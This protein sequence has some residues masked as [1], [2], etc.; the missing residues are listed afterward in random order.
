V[1][2]AEPAAAM[3]ALQNCLPPDTKIFIDAGNCVGWASHYMAVSPPM[4]M[5]T[6]LSMGPMGFAVGAVVGAK[7]GLPNTTCVGIT[8]DGAF[9]MHGSEISTAKQNN[10]GAIWIVLNDNNLNMVSQ[11]MQEYIPDTANPNA[12]FDLYGLGNPDLVAYS[13]ALGAEAYEVNKPGDFAAIMPKVLEG[14]NVNNI[15]QVVVIN[16]NPT[17]VTPY[18]NPVYFPGAPAVPAGF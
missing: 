3:G 8:G 1:A 2:P 6:C 15:P 14:A 17:S 18:Y 16:I 9:M 4:E 13:K 7:V 10:I 11:G 12:W 5:F